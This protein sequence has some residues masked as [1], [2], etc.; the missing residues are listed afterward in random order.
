MKTYK[1]ISLKKQGVYSEGEVIR[2]VT[3]DKMF[4]SFFPE[5]DKGYDD[6]WHYIQIVEVK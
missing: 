2:T 5:S 3:E 6:Q 1:I 4:Y